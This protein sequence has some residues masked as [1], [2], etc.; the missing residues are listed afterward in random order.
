LANLEEARQKKAGRRFAGVRR[1][2]Q[3]EDL[4]SRS[5]LVMVYKIAVW[6]N[7]LWG[8]PKGVNKDSTS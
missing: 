6:G 5:P 3:R 1:A 2:V 8:T 4:W 7:D